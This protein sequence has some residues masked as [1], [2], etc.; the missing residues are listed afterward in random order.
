SK[1]L[2]LMGGHAAGAL[3]YEEAYRAVNV[4][5]KL[6]RQG[7]TPDDMKP[8]ELTPVQPAASAKGSW[9]AGEESRKNRTAQKSDGG[10]AGPG[11][12]SGK[13]LPPRKGRAMLGL[14]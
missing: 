2:E 11:E 14:H 7:M 1:Y 4:G 5:G 3:P 9:T 8:L 10:M 12:W 13:A 6:F